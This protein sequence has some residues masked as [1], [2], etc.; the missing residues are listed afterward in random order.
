MNPD[1]LPISVKSIDAL[2][3][4]W[5]NLPNSRTTPHSEVINRASRDTAS[6]N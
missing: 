2:R 5:R 3:A 6:Q 1:N 4:C